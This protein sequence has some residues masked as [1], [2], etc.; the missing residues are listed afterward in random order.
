M[1][2]SLS[3]YIYILI[4]IEQYDNVDNDNGSKEA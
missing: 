4:N 3:L 1:S 2:L